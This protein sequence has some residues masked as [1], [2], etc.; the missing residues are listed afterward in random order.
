MSY[1]QYA[2]AAPVRDTFQSLYG[3]PPRLCQEDYERIRRIRGDFYTEFLRDAKRLVSEHGK[4]LIVE[5]ESGM[6]VPPSLDCRMQRP[7]DWRTWLK[8]GIPDEIRLK[9]WTMESTFVH[10]QVLPL[11]RQRCIPVHIISRCLHTGLDIRAREMAELVIGGACAAGFSG[12]SF[13]EQ[14]N[15][16]DL[17]PEGRSTLKGPV[18]AYFARAREALA[19]MEQHERNASCGLHPGSVR[20]TRRGH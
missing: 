15:L 17:S 10:E 18:R 3:R 13:Y 16:M 1:L 9:W 8:E 5:L 14:Q 12:Y 7:M 2:F 19:A 11:A 6:E 20:E 4:K